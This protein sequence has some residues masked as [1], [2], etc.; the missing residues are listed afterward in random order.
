MVKT[1]GS[2][3]GDSGNRQPPGSGPATASRPSRHSTRTTWVRP[4]RA[5]SPSS[6]WQAPGAALAAGPVS[7][8]CAGPEREPPRVRVRPRRRWCQ[9]S[10][11][12]RSGRNPNTVTSLGSPKEEIRR[13]PA[14]VTVSTTIPYGW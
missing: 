8:T 9:R 2:L 11:Y 7:G 3:V 4:G 12:E 5:Y 13:I 6:G 10:S 1:S 14:L